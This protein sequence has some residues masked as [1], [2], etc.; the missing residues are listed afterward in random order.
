LTSADSWFNLEIHKKDRDLV[1][2]FHKRRHEVS[3]ELDE[4]YKAMLEKRSQ[5]QLI[6]EAARS[7]EDDELKEQVFKAFKVE[8][9]TWPALSQRQSDLQQRLSI[10][11][12]MEESESPANPNTAAEEK[13]AAQD[14]TEP[15]SSQAIGYS[16]SHHKAHRQQ[17]RAGIILSRS[18][19]APHTPKHTSVEHNPV[20]TPFPNSVS[21]V[22]FMPLTFGGPTG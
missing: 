9:S 6:L 4:K 22:N 17:P 12:Q 7:R 16:E 8:A 13:E 15:S 5:D 10:N 1:E 3:L 20:Q 2:D 19:S 14:A 21:K 11:K 18:K